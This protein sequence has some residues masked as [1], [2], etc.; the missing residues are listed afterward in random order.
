MPRRWDATAYSTTAVYTP[1]PYVRSYT[2]PKVSRAAAIPYVYLAWLPMLFA[3][4]HYTTN[5]ICL[6]VSKVTMKPL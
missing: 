5:Y 2:N 1:L 6:T 3:V 4:E